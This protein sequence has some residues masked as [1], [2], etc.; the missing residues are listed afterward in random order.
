MNNI[1]LFDDDHW[2]S[3]LPLTYTKPIADLRI[4]ILK[5][6][7]KWSMHLNGQTS[8][9]TQD[10]LSD[11]FPIHISSDNYVINSRLLPE[12]RLLA[13]IHKLEMNEALLFNDTLLAARMNNLQFEQLIANKDLDELKGLELSKEIDVVPLIERPHDIF[14]LNGAEIIKDFKLITKKKYS[15]PI[16]AHCQTL[17]DKDIFIEEGAE[18]LF[19]TL[20]ATDGP[21]YIGKNSKIMEGCHIRGP[22]AICENSSLKMGARIYSNTT[23]GPLTKAGGEI[24]N[25]VFQGFSSKSHDGYLGNSVIGEWCNLG[26]DTNSSNLKNNYSFV[27]NWDYSSGS[28]KDTNLQFCGLIM[29]DHSKTGINTMFNTGTVIGVGANIFGSGYPRKFIP[30]FSWGGPAGYKTNQIS[31]ML[32]VADIVMKRRGVTLSES[33]KTI[34]EHI[35]HSSDQFRKWEG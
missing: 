24:N 28:F 34:L 16:P 23:L 11:K 5:I 9:I 27:K 20:N 32:E 4:G 10:Y 6:S 3:L 15:R 7:E 35:F 29:G 33:D 19:S 31:K 2:Q 13:L 18:I 25:V 8:Y 12:E 30:S 26:A 21:I 1:I 22:F 17:N 14:K